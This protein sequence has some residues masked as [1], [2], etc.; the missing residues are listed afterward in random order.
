MPAL[1]VGHG[2]SMIA[3]ED[4]TSLYKEH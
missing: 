4:N 3:I 2:N 1:F